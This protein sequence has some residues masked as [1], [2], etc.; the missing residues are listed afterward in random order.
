LPLSAPGSTAQD[1][2]NASKATAVATAAALRPKRSAPRPSNSNPSL[3]A[4]TRLRSTS[5]ATPTANVSKPRMN[6]GAVM[7]GM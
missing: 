3:G 2:P 5:S 7:T 4:L 6:S 1:Q